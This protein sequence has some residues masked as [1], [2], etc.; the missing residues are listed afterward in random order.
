MLMAETD[1]KAGD[2]EFDPDQLS[3]LGELAE[4]FIHEEVDAEILAEL[5]RE[6]R[7]KTC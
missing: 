2:F 6:H 4:A 1:E 7:A 3:D 5:H